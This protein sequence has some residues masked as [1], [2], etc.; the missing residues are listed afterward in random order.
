MKL[1]SLGPGV[2]PDVAW[3]DGRVSV[4]YGINPRGWAEYYADGTLVA[5]DRVPDNAYFPR[6]NGLR[7]VFSDGEKFRDWH[8]RNMPG[9]NEPPMGNHPVAIS[10]NGR[11][12][13]QTV[14]EGAYVVREWPFRRGVCQGAPTGLWDAYDDGTVV[15]WDDAFREGTWHARDGVTVAERKDND[16]A[17]LFIDGV[18]H[19]LCAEHWIYEPRLAVRGDHVAIVWG[20]LKTGTGVWLW[21]GTRDELR[22]L[23]LAAVSTPPPPPSPTPEPEGPTMRLTAAEK[24][25]LIA[26]DEKFPVAAIPVAHEDERRAWTWKLAQT[27]AAR[28]TVGWGTKRA[29]ENRPLSKDS[30]AYVSAGR[31]YGFD[32]VLGTDPLRLN[33]DC[34][35]EDITGQ[36]YVS[37]P[38]F[39]WLAETPVPPVEPP[40]VTPGPTPPSELPSLLERV[41]AIESFLSETFKTWG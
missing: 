1:V 32:V 18:E 12:F 6:T 5:T 37:V 19:W 16:G 3:A 24:A 11:V 27:F 22:Q 13:Y 8:G 17:R 33:P 28:F 26:F 9:P 36:V 34:D 38:A 21:L 40:P 29:D 25:T 4:A 2:F 7:T 30:I 31:L 35:G 10:P 39:D 20:D 15:L 23:P 41:K 14:E